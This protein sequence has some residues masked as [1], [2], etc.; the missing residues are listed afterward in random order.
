M[1]T[2]ASDPRVR[3][4]ARP[5]GT[6]VPGGGR[7][8]RSAPVERLVLEEEHRIGVV[9]RGAQEA[10]GVLD[11]AGADDLEPA[12]ARRT[13]LPASRNGKGRRGRRRRSGMRITSG[14]AWPERQCVFA[15][16]VTITSKGQVTKSANWSS[17]T[18]RS[19]I[20]AA[21]IAAPTN[22][23][24]AIGVSRTRSSPNSSS[25]P[26]VT[27]NA[28]PKAPMSSPSRKTRSSSRMASASA[29]RTASR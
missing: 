16:T 13:S 21:P 18:G 8:A 17:T 29:A 9:D 5:I 4:E 11:R 28:P 2:V 24:S 15:A 10:V 20:Q 6:R 26:F 12:A 1:T 27:P 25:R 19:P 14:I 22:P 23:S 3:S 7:S